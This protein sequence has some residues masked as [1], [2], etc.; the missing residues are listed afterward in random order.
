[1]LGD[2]QRLTKQKFKSF[3]AQRYGGV[4]AEKLSMILQFTTPMDILEYK[5]QIE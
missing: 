3:I 2:G 5:V 1:M 4:I